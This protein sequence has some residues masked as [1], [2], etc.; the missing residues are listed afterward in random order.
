[1]LNLVKNN[2]IKK[3]QNK[4]TIDDIKK[5]Y[6][7]NLDNLIGLEYE[8]LSLDKS[9]FKNASYEK[10]EKIIVNF[11]NITSWDL[12]CDNDTIIGAIS[13]DGS[14]ISLEPGCQL[15]ISLAPKKDLAQ[16]D[17]KMNE[18]INL[19]DNIAQVYDVIFLGYG[20]S[21]VSCV[22]DIQLL[23]KRRY[24]TMD[25][26]LPNRSYGELSQK[27]MRQTA[28]IQINIDYKNEKD[29][30][31]KLKFLNLIMPFISALCANSPFENN[32]LSDVKSLRTN[33]WR[34]TG[35]ERCNLFYKKVFDG[36]FACNHLF[37]NYIN[38]ILN[39][40]MIFI[41]RDNKI[42]EING[43]I[44]FAQFIK[45]GFG[46]YFATMDDYILHQSLCFP[47]VRL[48]KYIE[49]R[50]HDSA[51]LSTAL[52]LCALYKGLM[53]ADIK[54]CLSKFNYLKICNVD[55]YNQNLIKMV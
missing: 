10:L 11:S 12:I 21:P 26:F 45:N 2:E 31:Y 44:N 5:Y 14:S 17:F 15:E 39:V 33:V 47:D 42:V 38:E 46:G 37:S 4:L 13:N 36:F 32:R 53:R 35:R 7:G 49:I 30:F 27:M 52:A 8:R 48:K 22:D 23:N 34:Y 28:G 18:I 25:K 29:A 6:K 16:I 24:E 3:Q 50:N 54:Q 51:N 41:E 20:I 43:K 55:L 40:S 1:M 9:T 19:L